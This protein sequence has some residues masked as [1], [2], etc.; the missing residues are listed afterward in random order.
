MNPVAPILKIVLTHPRNRDPALADDMDFKAYDERRDP[1]L[2]KLKPGMTPTYFHVQQLKRLFV[3]DQIDTL[4]AWSQQFKL[5]FNAACHRVE[6]PG[7]P[8]MTPDEWVNEKGS[9]PRIADDSWIEQFDE[10]YDMQVVYEVGA[11]AIKRAR[12][13][14]KAHAPLPSAPTSDPTVSSGQSESAPDA[15]A[16]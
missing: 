2:I 11:F 16:S 1:A 13:P 6:P 4:A 8:A 3:M 10:D 7:K 5:A 12:L 14:K 9:V 15:G